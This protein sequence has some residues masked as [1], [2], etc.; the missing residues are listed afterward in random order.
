LSL[1]GRLFLVVLVPCTVNALAA[2]DKA[3][4]IPMVAGKAAILDHPDDKVVNSKLGQNT[5]I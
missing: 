1:A 2:A 3:S 5:S 4:E